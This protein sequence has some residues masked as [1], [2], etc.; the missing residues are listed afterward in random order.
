MLDTSKLGIQMKTAYYGLKAR[1]K[2]STYEEL[3]AR[4][5]GKKGTDCRKERTIR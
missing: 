4:A 3:L 1:I 2:G 5:L